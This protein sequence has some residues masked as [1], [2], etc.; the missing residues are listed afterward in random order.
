MPTVEAVTLQ[1]MGGPLSVTLAVMPR[2]ALL[3]TGVGTLQITVTVRTVSTTVTQSYAVG[4][5]SSSIGES[6]TCHDMPGG[7]VPSPGDVWGYVPGASLVLVS[8]TD[9]AKRPIGLRFSQITHKTLLLP[10]V[11]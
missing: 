7:F 2:A 9:S 1:E 10:E 3:T 6:A 4:L 5:W 8:A 11:L